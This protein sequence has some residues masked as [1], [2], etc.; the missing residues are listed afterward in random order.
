MTLLLQPEP[1]QRTLILASKGYQT[2]VIETLH[3]LRVAHLID[4][5]QGSAPE[6]EGFA[7][8]K[9]LAEGAKAS[10]TLVRVRALLRHLG[11]EGAEP[12][13]AVPA[14]DVEMRLDATLD[15][16]ERDVSRAAEAR[17]SLRQKLQEG[18][19]T[20]AKLQP[21]RALP[22][23]LEDY[24][25]YES[26]QAFV[27]RA[28]PAFEADVLRAAPDA[29]LVK[30]TEGG[31]FA[32]F[33]PKVLATAASEA[34]YRHGFAEV[35]VP[36]GSGTP[37][38]RVRE[39]AE[40]RANLQRQAEQAERDLARLAAE[41]R[42]TLLGAEEHLS[43]L[44]EKAE[45]PLA[46]ASTENAFVVDAWMPKADVWK[47]EGEL[48]KATNDNV[49]FQAFDFDP[50]AHDEHAHHHDTHE[51]AGVDAQSEAHAGGH[52]HKEPALP[53]TK[54]SNPGYAKPYTWFTELF[55]TPRYDEADP[56]SVFAIF[57]PIFF[58]FMVGDLGLGILIALLGWLLIRKLPKVD[59]MKQLGTFFVTGGLI[60]AV[61]GGLVFTDALGIPFGFSEHMTEELA[62]E[63]LAPACTAEV[64]KVIHETTW[65][66]LL[67]GNVWHVSP[68]VSKVTDVPS[69]LLISVGAA[70][71]HLLIGLLLGIRN[72]WS[73]GGKH[74]AAK[75]GYLILLVTFFPAAAA[76]VRP[77][78]FAGYHAAGEGA[79]P[80]IS[81]HLPITATQAY[82]ALGGGLVVGGV[83]LGWAEGIAGIV[84][85]PSMLTAILSYLR[86]G[87]VG[88]AK[89][90]MAVAFNG[91][92]LVA[93]LEAGGI[94]LVLGI[95]GFLVAQAA[96]LVL[97]ILSGG[98]QAL[99]LNFVEFF[100]KFYKGGGERYKPFGRERQHTTLT[101]PNP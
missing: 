73:H 70:F 81:F 97:G 21:L 9:P 72:E 54:Y 61:L 45:A 4:F 90:A 41:H 99:R 28:D 26:L 76:L 48:R 24:R 1:M 19:E 35:E 88:I 50:H 10:E 8:G 40:E 55:A 7:M 98:I 42:D 71:V 86:L 69:M 27:G 89:G 68:M 5:Q 49:H 25:G 22:L 17:D 96:L 75:F 62:V 80:A 91:M 51:H 82:M 67:G 2:Q 32:L 47:V 14:R 79:H 65:G 84:E 38:E 36:A 57:F 15:S 6:Y 95:V 92:T 3:R 16:I 39:L 30:G 74:L 18:R 56:T 63:G 52:T 20:E 59:G 46:F 53:P 37:D 13:R 94:V 34:L 33:V 43:I 58:G 12:A 31:L 23:K 85:L 60:A 100:T 77:D 87:A 101:T 66:C 64:Y 29:L 11:L 44:V 83:I 78:L 93:G